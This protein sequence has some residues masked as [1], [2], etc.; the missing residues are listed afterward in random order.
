MSLAPGSHRPLESRSFWPF[1]SSSAPSCSSSLAT[2]MVTIDYY[3]SNYRSIDRCI[4]FLFFILFHLIKKGFRTTDNKEADENSRLLTEQTTLTV[5]RLWAITED[6][7]ILY[8][9]NW[10]ELARNEMRHYQ[11]RLVRT[12]RRQMTE[13]RYSSRQ[14]WTFSMAFLYSVTLVT[15]IGTYSFSTC[16][17]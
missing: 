14:T 4:D 11:E 9:D 1:T 17:L 6:L 2:P 13:E 10:T 5:D 12:L 7:N 16:S 8:R 3:Q 15:T